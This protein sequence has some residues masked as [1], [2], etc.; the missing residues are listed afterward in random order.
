MTKSKDLPWRDAI[1]KVLREAGKPLHYRDIAESIVNEGLRESV[2]ATPA[3]TVAAIITTEINQKK[4]RA[5]VVRLGGG[6]YVW[7]ENY[8]QPE[9]DTVEVSEEIFESEP[10]V[11]EAFGMF[12]RRS[13]VEWSRKPTILGQETPKADAIDFS[14]QLGV[15]LLH[16]GKEIV[17]VG[18]SVDRP[19][20]LRLYEHTLDRLNGR[21][22]RFSWFGVIP[23]NEDGKLGSRNAVNID[24]DLIIVT[25]EALLIEALEPPLNRKRGDRFGASEYIQVSDP[26]IERKKR[27]ALLDSIRGAI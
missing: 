25:L 22:D 2:G 15:Y 12:W 10:S 3:H 7:K 27:H 20:G 8:V 13:E 17:Y 18:R 19:L 4:G 11:I 21:W 26:E 24:L 1:H 23:V 16:D 6:E 9:V 5:K 14:S